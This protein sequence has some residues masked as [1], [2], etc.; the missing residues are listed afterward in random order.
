[1]DVINVLDI[2]EHIEPIGANMWATVAEGLTCGAKALY[3]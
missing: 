3:I 1:M 2:V